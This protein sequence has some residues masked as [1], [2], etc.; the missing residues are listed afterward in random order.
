MIPIIL[1]SNP[2]IELI[3][4]ASEAIRNNNINSLPLLGQLDCINA[5]VTEE[6]NGEFTATIQVPANSRNIENV[7]VRGLILLDVPKEERVIHDDWST[8]EYTKKTQMFRVSRIKQ[9]KDGIATIELNHVS[10]D[11][12]SDV[13]WWGTDMA[14]ATTSIED[15][16]NYLCRRTPSG[17]YS[18][19]PFY[20]RADSSFGRFTDFLFITEMVP[21]YR[22]AAILGSENSFLYRLK[23]SSAIKNTEGYLEW[24][25]NL[26][27]L[28]KKRGTTK[29]SNPIS[30]GK[31]IT[32]INLERY[33]DSDKKN[34]ITGYYIKEIDGY[35]YK[36]C[37]TNNTW[38]EYSQVLR[39][40]LVDFSNDIETTLSG[41]S[42]SE[43]A[44]IKSD[45]T[46]KLASAI[47]SYS[48]NNRVTN[49]NFES[50]TLDINYADIDSVDGLGQNLYLGDTV[51]INYA[52]WN[53]SATVDIV[54]Y[55]WDVLNEKYNSITIGTAK[56]YFSKGVEKKAT[57][58]SITRMLG[59]YQGKNGDDE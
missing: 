12:N 29:T 7:A 3:V 13:F 43:R 17:I 4:I 6:L 53:Y 33:L 21:T 5:T 34:A 35:T 14:P 38:S 15:I 48:S 49:L 11:L 9:G 40:D 8:P 20:G 41:T 26:V 28:W 42:S 36:N 46:T 23:H 31:N 2:N 1:S 27:I 39:H 59:I 47:R 58:N 50:I 45:L 51:A 24:D 16:L 32:D 54:A 44:A 19:S 18:N 30:F 37:F 55:E 52:P 22:R 25:N 10:Y 56:S 57:D